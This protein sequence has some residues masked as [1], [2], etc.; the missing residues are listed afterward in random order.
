MIPDT[1]GYGLGEMLWFTC[2]NKASATIIFTVDC[3]Y[4][5]IRNFVCMQIMNRL[6]NHLLNIIDKTEIKKYCDRLKLKF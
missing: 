3:M 2:T 6:M 4:L 1:S 5:V